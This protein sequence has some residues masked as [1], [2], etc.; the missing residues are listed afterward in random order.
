MTIN[1]TG[2]SQAPSSGDVQQLGQRSALQPQ[3]L[4]ATTPVAAA[5]NS[6]S[7]SVPHLDVVIRQ[8]GAGV[9]FGSRGT[10]S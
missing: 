6:S 2:A 5:T 9:T 1:V 8:P 10:R 3:V 7:T 4:L